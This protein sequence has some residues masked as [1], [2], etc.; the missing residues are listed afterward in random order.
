VKQTR[1]VIV[2]EN[3]S[4]D[5]HGIHQTQALLHPRFPNKVSYLRRYV[6]KLAFLSGFE[7]EFFG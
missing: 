2:D 4:R 5:M 6:D 1:F 3:R 7:P